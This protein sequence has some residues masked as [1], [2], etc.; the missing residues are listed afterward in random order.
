MEDSI[1]LS[2]DPFPQLR[3][4]KRRKI[5]TYTSN[6]ATP[7]STE[8]ADRR[9]APRQQGATREFR[10][11]DFT[12]QK[13]NENPSHTPSMLERVSS[14]VGGIG[15]RLFEKDTLAKENDVEKPAPG[16]ELMASTED[17]DL[18]NVTG[19]HRD[20]D[21]DRDELSPEKLVGTPI[22]VKT[23]SKVNGVIVWH[24]HPGNGERKVDTITRSS[25]RQRRRPRRYSDDLAD[26]TIST[27][28]ERESPKYK[29]ILTPS[30]RRKDGRGRKRKKSVAFQRESTPTDIH[31]EDAALNSNVG[32]QPSQSPMILNGSPSIELADA[33]QAQ[34]SI[35]IEPPTILR[36]Y[37]STAGIPFPDPNISSVNRDPDIE[38][39]RSILLSRLTHRALSPIIGLSGEYRKIYTLLSQTVT[40][41]EGNSMLVLGSRGV[42]KTLL[43]ETALAELQQE[44]ADE[45]HTIRLSGLFQTDDRLALQ[46]IWRQL[47]REMDITED[48]NQVGSYAD[49]LSSLLA[50][51][52]HPEELSAVG[53][54][55]HESF[56]TGVTA[57]SVIFIMDEFDLFT[58]HS[59]Q[60]LLYNL[61]D[62][63]QARKAPVAVLGL[64]T[65]LDV[66]DILEKRVK[67]RFSQRYVFVPSAKNLNAF[68]ETCRAALTVSS[69]DKALS[70]EELD[71]MIAKRWNEWVNRLFTEDKDMARH[72]SSIFTTSK[73]VSDF[74]RSCLLPISSLQGS[75]KARREGTKSH[76]F[77]NGSDFLAA[78]TALA[79]PDNIL[80][81]ICAL[82]H[83]QLALLICAARF[84]AIYTSSTSSLDSIA[85]NFDSVYTEYVRL[86]S[87]ARI[88]S[89]V[90]GSLVASGTSRIWG[91]DAAEVA[92]E[93]LIQRDLLVEA[94]GKGK[95]KCVR[96]EVT[97]EEILPA[98]E[99][100]GGRIAEDVRKWCKDI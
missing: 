49:T 87:D 39:L 11:A 18:T 92:W 66:A 35:Q 24:D 14:A 26:P 32:Q 42:G 31:F 72:L 86:S 16:H 20:S 77:P 85:V 4:A 29:G 50:L 57:K 10:G 74:Q 33:S 59:R 96:V 78:S 43:V 79:S 63:A 9:S 6:R 37:T 67:S 21:D 47:G 27:Q 83:L 73:N 61:F 97:L 71:S 75:T 34:E 25:G 80:S 19:D 68:K 48:E 52:S 22:G 60:T 84:D 76:Y 90:S 58:S 15:R 64:T 70:G 45:F 46:E 56:S 99:M 88:A 89:S 40:A 94:S 65:R 69:T 54:G 62:I 28:K 98:V 12:S 17:G 30:Q 95:E 44:H 100:A 13:I 51:L 5:T 55:I 3:S 81:E 41:G 53:D 93:E 38:I 8:A 23:A 36:D 2:S 7:K 91:R 82:P 1:E